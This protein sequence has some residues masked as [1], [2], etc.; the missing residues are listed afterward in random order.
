MIFIIE[1]IYTRFWMVRLGKKMV[2]VQAQKDLVKRLEGIEVKTCKK[3]SQHLEIQK[4]IYAKTSNI[5]N[6][7]VQ[8]EG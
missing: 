3:E 8:Q 2:R 6:T 7:Y 1:Y 4:S 5:S